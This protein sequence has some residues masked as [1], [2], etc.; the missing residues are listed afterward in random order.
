[1][2]R[3]AR[4]IVALRKRN[5][6]ETS[7]QRL[8]REEAA[9]E[10][11]PYGIHQ[12]WLSWPDLPPVA[13]EAVVVGIDPGFWRH[14]GVDWRWVWECWRRNRRA[15]T[16]K[17]GGST[18]SMQVVKN[19]FFSPRRTYRRKAAEAI[20][21]PFMELVLGKERV[22]EIYLNIAEWGEGAFGI[23]AA[24]EIH[25]GKRPDE[26]TVAEAASL[27]AVLPAPLRWSPV[28]PPLLARLGAERIRRRI[29]L[30]GDASRSGAGGRHGKRRSKP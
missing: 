22:L 17:Q 15:G 20:L 10:G 19:L 26:L 3:A 9:D 25:F 6:G 13:K 5:P 30:G 24:A 14:H 1:M 4:E 29:E 11:R 21:A 18:L 7:F 27:A 28:R 23:A 16:R 2:I 12:R 8:R